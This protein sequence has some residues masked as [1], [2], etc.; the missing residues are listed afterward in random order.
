M[1]LV[2]VCVAVGQS[3]LVLP[4]SFLVRY[5]F[6]EV[7][8]ARDFRLLTLVGIGILSLHV[9]SSGVALWTRFVTLRMTKRV[10]Q[11]YRDELLKKCYAFSR[12]FHHKVNRS[13]LHAGIVQDTE[14]LDVMS[15]ALVAQLFP[16]VVACLALSV[17]LIYINPLLFLVLSGIVPPLLLLSRLMKKRLKHRV[18]DF[19]RSFNKFS[20]GVLFVLQMMDVTKIQSA[21][22]YELERQRKNLDELRRTSGSMAW[23]QTAYGLLHGAIASTAGVLILIVGGMSVAS[24]AMTVGGLLSFYVIVNLLNNNLQIVLS[25]VPHVIAGNESLNALWSILRVEDSA[26]YT[27]GRRRIEFTGK[28]TFESVN[29]KYEDEQQPILDDISFTIHP[30]STVAITGANGAGKSTIAHLMLGFYRPQRGQLYADDCPFSEL[31]MRH[32]RRH[33]G[34]V[35]QDAELMPG[36][37]AENIAYGCDDVDAREMARASELA[38][39][40]EFIRQLPQGYDSLV[41]ENGVLLS[42]GQRQRIALARALLRRPKL[43][44]LDEPT[45]HLDD[46]SMRRLM[47]NLKE[48]NDAP[49]TLIIS[50]DGDVTGNAE[51]VYHLVEGRLCHK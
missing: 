25:S 15:N 17:V 4:I 29:F 27:S 8:P 38:T 21:E 48:M 1:L 5:A 42:G 31:D 11:Q 3:L 23:L 9:A 39:A 12:S 47:T 36:T 40:H 49:A 32:L 14:R 51:C 22:N 24:G 33:I 18:N 19:H 30:H 43:L 50:H 10:I 46:A 6:D 41:G 20:R 13:E 34:V 26:P 16:A 45:N 7:I 35:M 2:V 28:I 37:I 44:I